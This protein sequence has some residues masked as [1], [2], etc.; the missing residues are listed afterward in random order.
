MIAWI[1]V[2]G[3]ALTQFPAKQGVGYYSTLYRVRQRNGCGFQIFI[4]H[5]TVGAFLFGMGMACR[6]F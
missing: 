5:D 2:F 6:S 4:F 3:P 1:A